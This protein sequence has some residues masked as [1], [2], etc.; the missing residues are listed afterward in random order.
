MG[1]SLSLKN[2]SPAL[3][4]VTQ[5]AAKGGSR[6]KIFVGLSGG[7]CAKIGIVGV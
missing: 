3:F 7:F 5:R 6:E 4:L 1:S 2:A